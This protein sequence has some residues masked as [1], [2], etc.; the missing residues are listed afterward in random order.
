MEKDKK[1]TVAMTIFDLFVNNLS[2]GF[3]S[4]FLQNT[5]TLNR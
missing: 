1:F 2:G 4:L 5:F 3:F